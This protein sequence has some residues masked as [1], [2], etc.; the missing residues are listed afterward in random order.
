MIYHSKVLNRIYIVGAGDTGIAIAR[1]I[2]SKGVIGSVVA[3]LDDD[4]TKIGRT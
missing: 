3:F 2:Q 1:E 4:T